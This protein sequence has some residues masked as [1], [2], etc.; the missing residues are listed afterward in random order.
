MIVLTKSY[1]KLKAQ[2]PY[3]ISK[4]GTD[5][6]VINHHYVPRFLIKEYRP[7]IN[8]EAEYDDFV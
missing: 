2:V 1:G 6:V 3:N 5:W 8:P 4:E 7:E